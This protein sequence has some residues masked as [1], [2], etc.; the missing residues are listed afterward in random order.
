MTTRVGASAPACPG[1]SAS[2]ATVGAGAA[3]TPPLLTLAGPGVSARRTR[4]TASE[5]SAASVG[6]EPARRS[7]G[8]L[9]AGPLPAGRSWPGAVRRTATPEAE[10]P[11]APV[12]RAVGVALT[13]P[14]VTPTRPPLPLPEGPPVTVTDPDWVSSR[15][16]LL[17]RDSVRSALRATKSVTSGS[18]LS[19]RRGCFERST[20]RA[21][22]GFRQFR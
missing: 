8:V 15:T 11:P 9:P 12:T 5:G 3:L 10:L 18:S 1:S 13:P 21:A 7:W 19:D 17:W 6:A 20:C 22:S 2:T 4:V 14:A 16:S